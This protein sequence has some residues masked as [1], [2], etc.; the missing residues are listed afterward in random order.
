MK[1]WSFFTIFLL[2]LSAGIFYAAK[3]KHLFV[4]HKFGDV[5]DSLNGVRVYYNGSI[6]HI[7]GRNRT[8]DGYNLGLKYQCVE[9]VKRYYYEYYHH[10]MPVS[11]GDAKDFFDPYIT[12][13]DFNSNRGLRQYTN[14]SHSKPQVG[15]LLVMGGN[16]HG[17][18]AIISEVGTRELEIIQQNPGIMGSSRR[19][20]SLRHKDGLW[21]IK[22]DR[23]L[24]WLRKEK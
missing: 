12:D 18:V 23:I 8:A 21:T 10:K 13:G 19:I 15:D 7:D 17:H 6:D 11:Y 1:R 2:L 9:F 20:F 22:N 5:L 24:G 4:S 14:G 3:N 16:V